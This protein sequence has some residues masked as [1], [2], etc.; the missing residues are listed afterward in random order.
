MYFGQIETLRQWQRLCIDLRAADNHQFA[1]GAGIAQ[2]RRN[3]G[4]VECAAR[5]PVG[6]TSALQ[7]ASRSTASLQPRDGWLTAKRASISVMAGA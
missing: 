7:C 6:P 4:I 1:V 3:P 5:R 2:Q